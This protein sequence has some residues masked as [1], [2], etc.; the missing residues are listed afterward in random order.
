MTEQILLTMK[1]YIYWCSIA[2]F[3][4]LEHFYSYRPPTV[5][6]LLRGTANI[7]LSLFNGTI[8]HL[9]FTS[10]IV[11]MLQTS[12]AKGGGLLHTMTLPDWIEIMLGILVLDFTLY[13]WHLLNHVMPLLWRFHR[14][15]HSDMNMDV[16]TA[17]RFHLGEFLISG[18]IR[19][20]VIYT[21]G[22]SAVA[23][24]LFEILVNIAIQFHHSSL[25][26]N[27]RFQWLWHYL[28]V[29]P[30]L[31]RIHHSVKIKERDSNYGVLF[32]F[33]DRMFGTL[34]TD[35]AQEG[36]II[37]LGSHR[38]FNK[39]GFGHLMAMPFSRFTI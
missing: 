16:T 30:F 11:T 5:S 28:F 33:W 18:L 1:P 38:Q 36:I 25:A 9:L 21:F 22:L 19:L 15:H 31:H 2:L 10:T 8:Y 34:R 26:V 35:I 23:Y 6:K 13:V 32:S 20:V 29:P 7:S 14:V 3:L 37:G 27:S 24:F 17:N 4:L 12:P 39:L